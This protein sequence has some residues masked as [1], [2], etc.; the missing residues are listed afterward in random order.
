VENHPLDRDARLERLQQ[1]PGD[2]LA[3]S[4]TVSGQIELVDVLEQV[5]Q[6]GDGALLIGTDDVE[7]LEV[8]IDVDAKARPRL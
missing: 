6:L 1:M 3:L 8:G 7:R 5:L 2:G 4:V